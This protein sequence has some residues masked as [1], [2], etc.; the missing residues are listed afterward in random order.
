MTCVT[1]LEA[2]SSLHPRRLLRLRVLPMPRRLRITDLR[3]GD[4]ATVLEVFNGLSQQSRYLRFHTGQPALAPRLMRRLTAVDPHSHVAHIALLDGRPVGL[5]RW[6]RFPGEPTAADLAVEVVDDVHGLGVGRALVRRAA[7]SADAAGIV[8]FL[9][10]VADGNTSVRD[11]AV[12]RGAV[13]DPQDSSALRLPI[14]ALIP[15]RRGRVRL[16]PRQRRR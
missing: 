3:P 7:V 6:I 10:Y 11:W 9:A 13:C 14:T 4:T 12:A 16:L 2:S 8:D 1:R 15:T 5:V